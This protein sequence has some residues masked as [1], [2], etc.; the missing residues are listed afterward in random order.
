[1]NLIFEANSDI[2]VKLS[3]HLFYLIRYSYLTSVIY[4]SFCCKMRLSSNTITK[5]RYKCSP[6]MKMKISQHFNRV[7]LAITS[8]LFVVRQQ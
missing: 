6:E 3:Q 1:M 2:K 8:N 5:T 4:L 7:K